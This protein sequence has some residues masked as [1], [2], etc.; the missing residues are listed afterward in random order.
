MIK[1]IVIKCLFSWFILLPGT[2]CSQVKI[3]GRVLEEH[4]YPVPY[5]TVKLLNHSKGMVSD[6]AGFFSLRLYALKNTDTLLISSVGYESLK[7]PALKA[8]KK[9]QY[10]LKASSKK[11]EAVVVRSFGKEDVAGAKLNQ[12]GYFRSWNSS[13]TGGEIGREIYVPYKEYQVSKVR[14]KIFSS[15]DTCIIRLHIREFKA[16]VPGGELLTDS[17][18]LTLVNASVADKSYDFDLLKYNLVFN[19]E[20]IFVS[21]EV[22]KGSSAAQNCSLSF[23]GSEPG[24]YI[25]K[26]SEAANWNITDDYSIHLKVFFRYD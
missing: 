15:C 4:N 22:L 18:A 19:K 9:G 1:F 6:T 10:I 20:N 2:I 24:S 3:E 13:N 25:Y 5:A 21:F 14:F 26:S 11:M 12:V 23:V 8:A 17:V 16:G 7:I